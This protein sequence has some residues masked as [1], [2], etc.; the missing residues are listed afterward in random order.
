MA[1]RRLRDKFF[2]VN[3][4]T[5]SGHTKLQKAVLHNDLARVESLIASGVKIDATTENS[6][7]PPVLMALSR[8]RLSIFNYILDHGG[9]CDLNN[10][11]YYQDK[12]LTP[13][14]YAINK[15]EQFYPWERS[16]V[17]EKLLERGADP[18]KELDPK[19]KNKTPFTM[20]IEKN[21][22]GVIGALSS[23]YNV[24][25]KTM[26]NGRSVAHIAALLNSGEALTKF[27]EKEPD[28][29]R[30]RS[31]DKGALPL[32]FVAYNGDIST[33]RGLS[34]MKDMDVN[35]RDY[36]G[37]TAMHYVLE[38][39]TLT[40]KEKLET[41]QILALKGA[42][43]A[44][45]NNKGQ[46]IL[47]QLAYQGAEGNLEIMHGLLKN[48]RDSELKK[49]V[50]IKDSEDKTPLFMAAVD[51]LLYARG[52]LKPTK[53]HNHLVDFLLDHGANPNCQDWRGFTPLDRL[54]EL[55]DRE[56]MVVQRLL[57]S[58]AEYNKMMDTEEV[59]DLKANVRGKKQEKP[60]TPI[61]LVKKKKTPPS[62]KGP[63]F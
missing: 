58:G 44:I 12:G 37:N 61:P 18:F 39:E 4:K 52:R 54:A 6:K 62:N 51:G 14:S 49:L 27:I 48:K 9:Y 38:N 29:L 3:G 35:A 46:T 17:I 63:K 13:L 15:S 8:K 45:A 43:I 36:N 21:D 5:F 19:D 31:K 56:S 53:V 23:S 7:I 59:A 57:K 25:L 33:I 32:M 41:L 16:E 42:D 10:H 60:S 20:A 30:I 26:I 55:A 47:H 50:N 28:L 22:R 24:D 34:P 1:H 2:D 11:D 40:P